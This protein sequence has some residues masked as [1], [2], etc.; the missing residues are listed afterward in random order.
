[1]GSDFLM[2]KQDT[3]QFQEDLLFLLYFYNCNWEKHKIHD[4]YCYRI[5]LIKSP[6][7]I[8]RPILLIDRYNF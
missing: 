7:P 6:D 1:M 5:M 8:N 3:R 2:R 4:Q